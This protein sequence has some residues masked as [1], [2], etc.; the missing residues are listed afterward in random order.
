M[1]IVEQYLNQVARW[2]PVPNRKKLLRQIRED[3]DDVLE[4]AK[5]ED[6]VRHHLGRFGKPP[7]VA[8][9]YANHP[10]VIPGMLAPSYYLVLGASAAIAS[11]V[12]VTLLIPGYLHGEDWLA[13][14]GS[15]FGRLVATL[16]VVYTVVTLVFSA[17]GYAVQ[18]RLRGQT[19]L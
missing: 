9:R 17:V 15:V 10:D 8:A 19:T 13:N 2:L 11:L 3:I 4:G 1:E 14:L 6:E 5:D 18:R 16:P 7:V 12:H